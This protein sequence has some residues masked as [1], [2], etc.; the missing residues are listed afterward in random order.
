M[1]NGCHLYTVVNVRCSYFDLLSFW[2]SFRRKID[3]D[4]PSIAGIVSTDLMEVTVDIISE[5]T[6][7]SRAVYSGAVTKNMLCAGHLSGGKDS[8]QVGSPC[9]TYTH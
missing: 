7:N 4:V 1:T 9:Q 2:T 3:P 6:C 8:C 5:Q